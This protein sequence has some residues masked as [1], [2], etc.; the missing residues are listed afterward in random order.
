MAESVV[1]K[2]TQGLTA[3]QVESFKENGF[4]G[5]FDLYAEDEAPLV[6][7][8]GAHAIDPGLAHGIDPVRGRR[9]TAWYRPMQ[10]T[11]RPDG[12]RPIERRI[13]RGAE[14]GEALA[15]D[16]DDLRLPCR[17]ALTL[18]A[19][20]GSP[21][22]SRPAPEPRSGE[23][24]QRRGRD[25]TPGSG[26]RTQPSVVT[27]RGG[28][29]HAQPNP[30]SRT[31]GVSSMSITSAQVGTTSGERVNCVSDSRLGGSIA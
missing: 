20:Q 18:A 3:E 7:S 1:H 22:A 15:T 4:L 19:P 10:W 13:Q 21:V 26:G 30:D 17:A 28:L 12:Q 16:R 2:V 24:R 27:Y 29:G 31:L 9:L 5:P 6:W 14:H 25:Q 23:E 11:A 8:V